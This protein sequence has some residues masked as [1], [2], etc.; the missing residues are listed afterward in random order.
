MLPPPDLVERYVETMQ[1]MNKPYEH[2]VNIT[3]LINGY[4]AIKIV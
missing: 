4:L 1:L 3:N 2:Q